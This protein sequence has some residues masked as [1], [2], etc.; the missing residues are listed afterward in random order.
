[1]IEQTTERFPRSQS[2]CQLTEILRVDEVVPKVWMV[3][4]TFE[5]SKEQ[6]EVYVKHLAE[7][8]GYSVHEIEEVEPA[9][10]ATE[11]QELHV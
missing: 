11:V 8:E 7:Q 5:A 1:V 2:N 9:L 3:A 10:N 4:V 6:H